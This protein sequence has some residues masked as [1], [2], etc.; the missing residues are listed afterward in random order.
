M[1][2]GGT[3]DDFEGAHGP[4]DLQHAIDC[5]SWFYDDTR[6]GVSKFEPEDDGSAMVLEVPSLGSGRYQSEEF[7]QA[8]SVNDTL[9][10]FGISF[11]A[12]PNENK[13]LVS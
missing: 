2:T 6:P 1:S 11:G 10:F 13:H 7:C 3:S 8:G 4:C 5:S 12:H 9:D